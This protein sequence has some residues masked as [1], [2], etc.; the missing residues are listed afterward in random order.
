AIHA[1]ADLSENGLSQSSGAMVNYAYVLNKITDN[2]RF[3]AEKSQ[4]ATSSNVRALA[5]QGLQIVSANA[6]SKNASGA[7]DRGSQ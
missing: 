6:A 4:V 7:R 2:L 1:N 5:R 3:F